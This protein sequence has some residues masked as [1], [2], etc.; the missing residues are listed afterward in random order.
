MPTRVTL[1]GVTH[2][3]T[4]IDSYTQTLSRG[5]T[6]TQH[7]NTHTENTHPTHTTEVEMQRQSL[8][9]PRTLQYTSR[10]RMDYT[11]SNTY[12]KIIL[13]IIKRRSQHQEIILCLLLCSLP[14]PS[15]VLSGAVWCGWGECDPRSFLKNPTG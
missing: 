7:L 5:D 12:S 8:R 9:R 6:T 2:N 14:R 13:S 15:F 4:H 3:P 11:Q 1:V 10:C